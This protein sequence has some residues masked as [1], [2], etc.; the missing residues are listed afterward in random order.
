MA[1]STASGKSLVFQCAALR[2]LE[3]DPEARVL[4]FY[5]LKALATDQLVSWRKA[6]EAAGFGSDL[7]G[8][9]TGSVPMDERANVI[10]T[11]RIVAMTP[12]VCQA[13]LM[14]NARPD[15]RLR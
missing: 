10:R 2:L 3:R 11:A 7:V 13:W 15:V 9:I 5:P 12:D 14:R 6:A 4:V 1:T 8:E